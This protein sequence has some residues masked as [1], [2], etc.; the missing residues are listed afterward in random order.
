D[1]DTFGAGSSTG[2]KSV[3]VLQSLLVGYTLA[4]E[5]GVA[6]AK[7]VPFVTSSVLC[8]SVRGS[9]VLNPPIVTTAVS[10][11]VVV[12]VAVASFVPVPRAGDKPLHASILVDST[13]AGTIR[14]D[15]AGPSQP[16]GTELSADTFYVSSMDYDQLEKKKLEGRCSRQSDLLK[17]EDVEI[18]SLKAQLSM[19]EAEAVE[20][21]RLHGQ[22]ATVEAV[23]ERNLALESEKNTLEGQVTTLESMARSKDTKLA[24]VNAQVAK[25]NDDLSFLQLSFGELSA[26][27]AN[28]ES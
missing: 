18:A 26:K 2:G 17:E 5:V 23:R 1:H 4:M 10:T 6:A 14:P 13:S 28:P 7:T 15:I 12:V 25:L 19:K 9:L 8:W 21:I 16:A 22:V 24:F 20:A 3:A 27:A 11:T